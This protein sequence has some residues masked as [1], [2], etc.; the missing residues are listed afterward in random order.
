M[1]N[2]VQIQAQRVSIGIMII[3]FDNHELMI[4]IC[5]SGLDPIESS[6]FAFDTTDGVVLSILY[7]GDGLMSNIHVFATNPT[8]CNNHKEWRWVE[9]TKLDPI[10]TLNVGTE[11]WPPGGVALPSHCDV[12]LEFKSQ[13]QSH[14][15]QRIK[16]GA[17]GLY[18]QEDFCA[19]L[20]AFHANYTI[21]PISMMNGEL[22]LPYVKF[23][24]H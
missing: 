14:L 3:V 20:F 10:Q 22:W 16:A 4:Y 18:V 11:V 2:V 21:N 8:P 1:T 17:I 19:S 23:D 7:R 15:K 13:H 5:E 9:D 24:K 6:L 12:Y